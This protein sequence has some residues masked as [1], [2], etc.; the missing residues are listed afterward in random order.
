MIK[1]LMSYRTTYN[2]FLMVNEIGENPPELRE[3][4][5]SQ[6]L[7]IHDEYVHFS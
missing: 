7:W 1:Y 5:I 4:I 2:I 3:K 6:M